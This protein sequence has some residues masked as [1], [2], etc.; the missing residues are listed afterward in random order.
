VAIG[1]IAGLALPWL[2]A[3]VQPDIKALRGWR[4]VTRDSAHEPRVAQFRL[5]L[6]ATARGIS[7]RA[8]TRLAV[9]VESVLVGGLAFSF[10]VWEL[11]V[12]TIVLQIGMLPLMARDFHRITL[13]SP[14]VNLLAVPLTSV[15]VPLGFITLANSLVF[16]VL[17]RA[18]GMANLAPAAFRA[19]VSAFF[20]RELPDSWTSFLGGGGLLFRRRHIGGRCAHGLLRTANDRPVSWRD[21]SCMLVGCC[22][23][24]F[25]AGLVSWKIGNDDPGCRS[26]G[27][28]VRGV[29]PWKDVVD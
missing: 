26:G 3:T 24:P 15:V 5:D 7:A 20:S 6:R 11:F 28:L 25:R 22:A 13:A 12:L 29:A 16:P 9:S 23:V 27:F 1:C 10:R 14:L 17:G 8:P 18:S 19:M 2:A 4:D 21:V